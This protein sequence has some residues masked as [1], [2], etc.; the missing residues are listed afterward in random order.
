MMTERMD[1]NKGETVQIVFTRND[2][3]PFQSYCNLDAIIQNVA[4]AEGEHWWFKTL[5]GIEF[6]LNPLCGELA[7]IIKAKKGTE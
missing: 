4:G 3:F 5:D 2:V 6:T 1:F 7:G